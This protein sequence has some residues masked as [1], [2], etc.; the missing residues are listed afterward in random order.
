MFV[1]F[2]VLNDIEHLKE[3]LKVLDELNLS[4]TV[5]DSISANQYVNFYSPNTV[6]S[7]GMPVVVGSMSMAD[8]DSA[9]IY[10]KTLNSVDRG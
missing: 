10:N 9:I 2:I 6:A 1:L 4:C 8:D 5:L 7:F 3:V